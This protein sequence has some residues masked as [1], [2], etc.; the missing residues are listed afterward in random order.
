[1]NFLTQNW[2]LIAFLIITYLGQLGTT[3]LLRNNLQNLEKV[4]EIELK[5]VNEKLAKQNSRVSKI[6]DKIDCIEKD[7]REHIEKFHVKK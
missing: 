7:E 5:G 1:M 2:E 3:L 6:E 4:M